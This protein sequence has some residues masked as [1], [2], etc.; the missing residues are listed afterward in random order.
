M[1]SAIAKYKL[2]IEKGKDKE[3]YNK[4]VI[5]KIDKIISNFLSQF[6]QDK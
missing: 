5:A 4:K 3:Q 6:P 2:I 1:N